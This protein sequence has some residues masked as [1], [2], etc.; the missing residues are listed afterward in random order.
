M[1]QE[2]I[3]AIGQTVDQEVMQAIGQTVDQEVIQVRG[4]II[5]QEGVVPINLSQGIR[6]GQKSRINKLRIDK[7][8]NHTL[9]IEVWLS[10]V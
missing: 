1:D 10:F 5:V 8:Y 3:Q 4:Q 6:D 9:F 2:V 7:K